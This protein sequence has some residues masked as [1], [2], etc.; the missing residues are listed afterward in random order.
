MKDIRS[1]GRYLSIKMAPDYG[2]AEVTGVSSISRM[3]SSPERTD[4]R[5]T[6]RVALHDL[7]DRLTDSDPGFMPATLSVTIDACEVLS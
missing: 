2:Y 5:S 6:L 1:P 4:D 3:Y 7:V